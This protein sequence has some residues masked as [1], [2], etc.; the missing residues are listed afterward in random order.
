MQTAP[1]GSDSNT[2][3]KAGKTTKQ[4]F[5][6]LYISFTNSDLLGQ[7]KYT[8]FSNERIPLYRR[9]WPIYCVHT[10]QNPVRTYVAI[11]PKRTLY[12]RSPSESPLHFADRRD[13]SVIVGYYTS[14]EVPS[15]RRRQPGAPLCE[16][17]LCGESTSPTGDVSRDS[18]GAQHPWHTT[19]VQSLVCYTLIE[20][21]RIPICK[22]PH[23]QHLN[24]ADM[25]L[26]AS[27]A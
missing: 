2:I 17:F 12:S 19:L 3:V 26:D 11:C 14:A 22:K 8:I 18:K 24:G 20:V 4:T 23:T 7:T 1:K 16:S 10:Y 5:F 9:I 21:Y 27:S 15:P 6:M 13:E 25:G